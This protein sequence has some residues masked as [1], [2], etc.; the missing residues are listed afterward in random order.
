MRCLH[1]SPV[2]GAGVRRSEIKRRRTGA[3]KGRRAVRDETRRGEPSGGEASHS[4]RRTLAPSTLLLSVLTACGGGGDESISASEFADALFV[5]AAAA[6]GG[7]G[8]RAR[9]FNSLAAV[10]KASVPDDTIVVLP[11][12]LNVAPLD[13]GIALKSGQWLIGGGAD[14]VQQQSNAAVAGAA[15][16][17]DA[18]PR[19]RNTNPQRQNGDA[20][21]LA[22]GNEVRNLVITASQRG[23]IYGLNAPGSVIHGNDVSGYNSLCVVGF[24]VEP[25]TAP[26]TGPYIG[27]P[28]VLPAGWAGIMLDADRGRGAVAINNNYVHDSACGNGIDLRINGTADYSAEISGNFV[29]NLKHG[30]LYQAQELHLV[31]AITTQITDNAVL[32]AV[33]AHNTQ[34][35]IGA[36]GADCEGLFMN[37]ADAATGYWRIDDNIFE[38]GI[39]GFSC[40]GMELIISN[41]SGHG[42]MRLTNSRFIDNPGDMFE[43]ANLGSGSTLILELDNVEVRDTHERGGHP[44]AGP[45]PFNLGECLLMGSTGTGNTTVLKI[46]DSEFSGCNNGLSILSGVN[47]ASNLLGGLTTGQPPSDPLGPDGLMSIDISNTRFVDNAFNNIVIGVIADLRELELK[48][49]NSDFSR[50]GE[51]AVAL[52]K[53]YLGNVEQATIDFGGGA[54]G[55]NG[56]NCIMGGGARDVLS[57]GF[58]AFLQRNWWGQAGGP[59]P[60]RLS[61][62]ST[63]SLDIQAPLGAAPAICAEASS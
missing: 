9:P 41:G 7:D 43:Q 38:H 42:E 13:G 52:R 27:V 59:D 60:S 16:T 10:E 32:N 12:P 21:R 6:D 45:I 36:P 26:S 14:V 51:N 17:L 62:A 46:R 49:E 4:R 63:D 15:A 5:S 30:P 22:E 24:I 33:S 3:P 25:F 31:H 35:F 57:E 53:I 40:N 11:A 8:S 29:T 1:R 50:A 55:S 47:L 20:V 37:L 28:A 56:G 18:L 58:A 19:I 2:L 61:A 54:L 39:G 44:D 34:T 23:A 48:V